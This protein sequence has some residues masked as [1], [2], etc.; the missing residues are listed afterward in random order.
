MTS[1]PE[2]ADKDAVVTSL[3]DKLV[4]LFRIYKQ[5]LEMMFIIKSLA[6]P[7]PSPNRNWTFLASSLRNAHERME[8]A[9]GD[10]ESHINLFCQHGLLKV[11]APE[12]VEFE[13]EM[14]T[15]PGQ[16][17]KYEILPLYYQV[18]WKL[19]TYQPALY[20]D[21]HTSERL[22]TQSRTLSYDQSEAQKKQALYE[23]ERRRLWDALS[24]IQDA[25]TANEVTQEA[26][27]IEQAWHKAQQAQL[28]SEPTT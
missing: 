2:M 17:E 11:M 1:V 7:H 5:F 22:A 13:G 4:P 23:N 8:H 10:L 14:V 26:L 19:K 3:L 15:W 25:I 24:A 6:P 9:R 12:Q 28:K 20:R 21:E 18:L 16:E 27:E